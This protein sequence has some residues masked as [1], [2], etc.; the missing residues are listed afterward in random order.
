MYVRPFLGHAASSDTRRQVSTN[1][2]EYPAWSKDGRELYFLGPDLAMMA[3]ST[4]DLAG[5]SNSP[6][7]SRL[8]T[9]C[10]DT[11]LKG[12]VMAGRS[13]AYPYDVAPDGRFV[14]NCRVARPP[15][16]IVVWNWR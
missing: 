15:N 5:T 11:G 7:A 2:G 4:R 10:P 9:V 8:F 14:I 6:P 3:V 13:W 12:D 16:P 1:G